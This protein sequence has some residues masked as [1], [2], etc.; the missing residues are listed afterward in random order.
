MAGPAK[1]QR[2][3]KARGM[4]SLVAVV[5]GA[6]VAVAGCSLDG[7]L[8]TDELPPDLTDPA[9]TETPQGA[10]AAYHGT[11]ASFRTVFAAG[12]GSTGGYTNV[13]EIAGLLSDELHWG[14]GNRESRADQRDL[15]ER[16]EYAVDG[17]YA[18]LHRVRGQARQAIGLLTEYAPGAEEL[19]GHLHAIKAYAEIFLAELYCSGIPLS[20]LD[21]RGDFTY[22]K[23]ST[24]EEVYEHALALLDTALALTGDS[25]RFA[26]LARVGKARALLGLGRFADAAAAVAA[27]PDEFRYEVVYSIA[28]G[29]P[30]KGSYAFTNAG[31][32][33]HLTV[34]DR[35][36]SNGLDYISS[37]DARTR[38]EP[39]WGVNSRGMH[40]Y[41]PSKYSPDGSSAILLASGVEARLVEA[42]A[43]LRAG[44]VTTWLGKLNHL[45]RTAWTSIVPPVDGPLEDLS[46]PGDDRAR[47]DVLFRERA[48]WLFL[49]GQRQGDMRR[50][51][52]HY[53]R[54]PHEVYPIGPYY[55]PSRGGLTYGPYVDLPI[56]HTEQI[57]N[58]HFTGCAA[59]GA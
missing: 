6:I 4:K 2:R 57:Y 42:E 54:T 28:S 53:G 44:D 41:F 46:D 49:T 26:N 55:H 32:L 19:I 38:V 21:Y 51:L 48:F 18:D 15:P 30:N 13:V 7:M 11:L 59:R 31:S 58:R 35:K 5:A 16:P 25:I 10:L 23:G 3:L 33:W 47:V 40:V 14:R 29:N 39:S 34:A 8:G 22:R 56:P 24:T 9:I 20:T 36:G 45:R 52:R 1:W 17:T 12:V 37:G 27:V 43:A 50:L